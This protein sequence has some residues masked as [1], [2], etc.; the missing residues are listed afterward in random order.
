VPE[1]DTVD[2]SIHRPVRI[3]LCVVED[4]EHLK[5]HLED[6][7]SSKAVTLRKAMSSKPAKL[8]TEDPALG[9]VPKGRLNLAHQ[10][11]V[12]STQSW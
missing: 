5:P 3:E 7:F 2:V 1:V 8:C 9:A 12:R 6:L 11:E 10:D 4:I